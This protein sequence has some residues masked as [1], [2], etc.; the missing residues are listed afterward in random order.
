MY[1]APVLASLAINLLGLALL[2]FVFREEYAGL[3]VSQLTRAEPEQAKPVQAVF[4]KAS[5][6]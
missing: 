4:E 3:H 6:T 1:T 2:V 5:F